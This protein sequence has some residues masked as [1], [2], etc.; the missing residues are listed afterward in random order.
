MI[1]KMFLN[2]IKYLAFPIKLKKKAFI[3]F[4]LKKK[5]FYIFDFRKNLTLKPL[6]VIGLYHFALL[7][8]NRKN[9]AGILRKLIN[10]VKF[11]GFADH[12]V[13]EAIRNDN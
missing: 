7:V 10:N 3:N 9:L 2:F 1:L 5:L 13:S 4:F 12:G 8:P 6:R 11:E